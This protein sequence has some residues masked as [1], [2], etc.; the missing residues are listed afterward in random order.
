[1]AASWD[2]V[3]YVVA[4]HHMAAIL[5]LPLGTSGRVLNAHPNCKSF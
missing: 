5:L 2:A 3:A 4:A 1:M